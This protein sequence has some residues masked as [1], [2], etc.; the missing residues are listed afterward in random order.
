MLCRVVTCLPVAG[1][2]G[3]FTEAVKAG[4]VEPNPEANKAL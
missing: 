3:V 4:L 2:L 1:V